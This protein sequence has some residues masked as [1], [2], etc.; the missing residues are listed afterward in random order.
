MSE[1]RESTT[2]VLPGGC[3]EIAY[4][5]EYQHESVKPSNFDY[6]GSNSFTEVNISEGGITTR[7]GKTTTLDATQFHQEKG[8][9]LGTATT[10]Q[11]MVSPEISD[12]SLLT[13][14]NGFQLTVKQAI[15]QGIIKR[16]PE[17]SYEEATQKGRVEEGQKA[18]PEPTPVE[19]SINALNQAWGED[20]VDKTAQLILRDTARPEDLREVAEQKG[21]NPE[22]FREVAQGIYDVY[23]D[24]AASLLEQVGQ[25]PDGYEALEWINENFDSTQVSSAGFMF[26]KGR[27]EPLLA[28]AREYNREIARKGLV[29]FGKA[30][31]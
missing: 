23:Y 20:F 6:D 29:K 16:T 15:E 18:S 12:E 24:K 25:V 30:V 9:I 8:K 26:F 4:N 28:M 3:V 17:G 10:Q 2:R 22:E 5:S 31:R 19:Q 1:S 27:P 13:L 21:L 7:S 11:G 14:P